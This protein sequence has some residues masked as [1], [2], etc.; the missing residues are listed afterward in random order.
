[1]SQCRLPGL[2][3][4]VPLDGPSENGDRKMENPKFETKMGRT[5]SPALPSY[6]IVISPPTSITWPS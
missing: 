2:V 3:L 5:R 4:A 6:W 1:M